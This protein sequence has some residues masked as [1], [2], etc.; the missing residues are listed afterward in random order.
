MLV[1]FIP[2]CENSFTVAKFEASPKSFLAAFPAG[3]AMGAMVKWVEMGWNAA[4]SSWEDLNFELWEDLNF[5]S[6]E[7]QGFKLQK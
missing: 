5:K 6:W 1:S 7:E 2:H 3:R 4:S